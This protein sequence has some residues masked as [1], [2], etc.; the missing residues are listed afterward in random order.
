[1]IKVFRYHVF[2]VPEI[3]ILR[4]Y[5][6]QPKAVASWCRAVVLRPATLVASADRFFDGASWK[7]SWHVTK[8]YGTIINRTLVFY[9]R[10]KAVPLLVDGIDL[11]PLI[12]SVSATI[13]PKLNYP[14]RIIIK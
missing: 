7:S 14:G 10:R 9:V 4:I 5:C 11:S 12:S 6:I 8:R 1:M 3:T 2:S 13:V